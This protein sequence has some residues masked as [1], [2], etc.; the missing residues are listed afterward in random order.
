MILQCNKQALAAIRGH[1]LYKRH[2]V[3]LDGADEVV[4]WGTGDNPEVSLLTH[5][6]KLFDILAYSEHQRE[7][8]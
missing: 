1:L 2:R 8:N 3:H 6:D 7:V 5:G 4:W